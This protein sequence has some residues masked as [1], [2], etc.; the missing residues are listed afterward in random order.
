MRSNLTRLGVNGS[1]PG[2]GEGTVHLEKD[3]TH[4]IPADIVTWSETSVTFQAPQDLSGIWNLAVSNGVGTAVQNAWGTFARLP[5][6]AIGEAQ[7][8]DLLSVNHE[9]HET[10]VGI[11]F[12]GCL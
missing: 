7:S 4:R 6:G 8:V 9:S 3:G 2:A 5:A 10:A 12:E 11:Q 1:F